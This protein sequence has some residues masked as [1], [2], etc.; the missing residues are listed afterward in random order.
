MEKCLDYIQSDLAKD[1]GYSFD[2]AM[3]SL[4]RCLKKLQVSFIMFGIEVKFP[5]RV[6]KWHCLILLHLAL[7]QRSRRK[8]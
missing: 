3:Q 5:F 8:L 6:T 7:L 2:E 4:E 1:F